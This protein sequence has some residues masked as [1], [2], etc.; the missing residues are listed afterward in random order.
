MITRRG[1]ISGIGAI[2]AA[3]AIVRVESIMPVK[4]IASWS[5]PHVTMLGDTI[6][7]AVADGKI[8]SL[9]GGTVWSD[10]VFTDWSAPL[11]V[12]G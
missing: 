10:A 4:A 1:I 9:K 5:E 2:I 12:N 6:F 7:F 11:N 3:P 8:W